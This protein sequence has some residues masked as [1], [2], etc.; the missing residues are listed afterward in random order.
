[1]GAA[2][3]ASATRNQLPALFRSHGTRESRTG[4]L[5]VRDATVSPGSASN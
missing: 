1:L 4:W 5:L 2:V 3:S